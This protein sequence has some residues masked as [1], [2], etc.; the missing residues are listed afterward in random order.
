[1]R[2][3]IKYRMSAMLVGEYRNA[4]CDIYTYDVIQECA[5]VTRG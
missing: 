4:R 2:S 5:L 3:D 1:M